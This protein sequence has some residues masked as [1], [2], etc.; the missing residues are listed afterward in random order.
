MG[1]HVVDDLVGGAGDDALV[2]FRMYFPEHRVCFSGA[3][4]PIGEHCPIVP[5]QH[6]IDRFFDDL[7][8]NYLLECS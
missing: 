2:G 4:L 5:I 6:L 3:G 1:V 7:V 8:V